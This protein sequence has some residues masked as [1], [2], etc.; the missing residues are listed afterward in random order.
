MAHLFTTGYPQKRVGCPI[1]I[2]PDQSLLAAPRGFSQP[3][4]SF[5]AS[6]CQGIHQ[7]PFSRLSYPPHTENRTINRPP[8]SHI[9]PFRFSLCQRP[10]PSITMSSKP[11][12]EG[13][14]KTAKQQA[15]GQFA[16]R[17]LSRIS[18][19]AK[20]QSTRNRAT[21]QPSNTPKRAQ[22]QKANQPFLQ[23]PTMSN[24]KNKQNKKPNATQQKSPK[25]RPNN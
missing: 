2:S 17:L 10:L 23:I 4:T 14:N 20:T 15:A 6:R 8:T 5:I 19:F 7:M 21:D 11:P 16:R 12:E 1:R 25:Q 13:Q 22:D 3:I 24:N 9:W 18:R